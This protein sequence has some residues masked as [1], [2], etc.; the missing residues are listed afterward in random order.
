MLTSDEVEKNYNKF[1][2][3]CEKVG[4]HRKDNLLKL[5]DHFGTRLALCPT[6]AKKDYHNAF[7]G[8]LVD[9]SLRV[10]RNVFTL[11]K[12]FPDFEVS[13]ES[14]V[15]VSLMHDIGKCGDLQNDFYVDAEE[16][17]QQKLNELYTYN[18]K[19]Q[20]MQHTHRSIYL[21]QHFNV[22]LTS[23]EFLAILLH[24]GPILEG[25]KDYMFK[26]PTL[27]TL[28]HQADYLAAKEEKI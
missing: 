10:L 12:M 25:N 21:L 14:L 5:V 18:N 24:D 13:K 4:D 6:S 1:V 9:H 27:A 3:L 8:G 17:R 22:Q 26:E 11:T 28:L 7:P 15:L 23:D 16:W 2:S 19:I 20:Y